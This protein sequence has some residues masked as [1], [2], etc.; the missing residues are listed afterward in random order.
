MTDPA[1]LTDEELAE[2]EVL[3]DALRSDAEPT[4]KG[5]AEYWAH[6]PRL[7]SD[8]RAARA[9]IANLKIEVRN[10]NYRLDEF[11]DGDANG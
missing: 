10:L 11:W 2:M 9:E 6:F 4:R 7:I 1:P 8:L 3:Y 5:A